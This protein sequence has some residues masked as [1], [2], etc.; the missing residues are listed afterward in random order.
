MLHVRIDRGEPTNRCQ[1]A[2]PLELCVRDLH[3]SIKV[4][5]SQKIMVNG[6]LAKLWGSVS[7]MLGFFK[8]YFF[9]GWS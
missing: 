7:S 6:C 8:G 4:A 2:H 1:G 5:G 3:N 9:L